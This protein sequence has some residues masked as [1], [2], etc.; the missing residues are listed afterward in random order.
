[1]SELYFDI[2]IQGVEYCEDVLSQEGVPFEEDETSENDEET[3]VEEEPV[4]EVQEEIV[5]NE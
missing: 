1:M 4:E 5:E 3:A 2:E